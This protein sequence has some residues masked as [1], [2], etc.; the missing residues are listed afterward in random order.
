MSEKKRCCG[1]CGAVR[2]EQYQLTCHR[3]P[4]PWPPVEYDEDCWEWVTKADK[5]A[6]MVVTEA[7]VDAAIGTGL[8]DRRV[9]AALL[10]A[11]RRLER[12]GL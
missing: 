11:E 3:H 8:T 12:G 2:G 7:D 9:A 6:P 5:H 1:T 10:V 4:P